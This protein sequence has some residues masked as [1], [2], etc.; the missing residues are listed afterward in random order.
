MFIPIDYYSVVNSDEVV[1]ILD[2]K[3]N[4]ARMALR[5]AKEEGKALKANR[6]YKT[7]SVLFMKNGMVISSPRTLK[8]LLKGI[9]N[10]SSPSA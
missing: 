3:G 2:Y 5:K 4:F 1:M 7:R 6:R 8:W 10:S 9:W